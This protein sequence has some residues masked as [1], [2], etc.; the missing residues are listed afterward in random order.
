M[1]G[2]HLR[3]GILIRRFSINTH[4]SM[5]DEHLNIHRRIIAR[6]DLLFANKARTSAHQFLDRL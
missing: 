1:L 3:D 5:Q 2:Y 6:P 4:I